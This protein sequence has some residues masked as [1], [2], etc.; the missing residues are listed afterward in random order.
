MKTYF[1]KI[2]VHVDG[3]P[4]VPTEDKLLMELG[5]AHKA[6]IF[7]IL[8][9]PIAPLKGHGSYGCQKCT[10]CE[11]PI[12][13]CQCDKPMCENCFKSPCICIK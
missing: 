4:C 8:E 9:Q 6:A 1:D 7:R 2:T 12:M 3:K 11:H 13:N 5:E 10:L